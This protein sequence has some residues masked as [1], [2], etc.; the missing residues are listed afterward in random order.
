MARLASE[1]TSLGADAPDFDLPDTDGGRVTRAD[2]A[3]RPLLVMFISNHCPY[4]KH[5]KSAFT[6]FANDYA[7]TPLRIVAIGSNSTVT[8]PQDGP[9]QMKADKEAFGYPF[10][11]V[12]DESQDVAR[13][14]GA[15]CTPDF[16]L[17]DADH[18][19]AYRGQFDATRPGQGEP[20]G[21]DMRAAV[22]TLLKGGTIPAD[23]QVPSVG[24]SIKW[25]P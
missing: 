18:R 9:A 6:A 20:T 25:H 12:F 23:G 24:C 3:G 17:F 8:H 11:Y 21:A 19:L 15:V 10:P 14:Y 7:D 13:A 2:Q 22:D 5:L 1:K 16:F 4:V